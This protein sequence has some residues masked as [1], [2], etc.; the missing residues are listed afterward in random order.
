MDFLNR[1][2]I[3]INTTKVGDI[4]FFVMNWNFSDEFKIPHDWRTDIV[5]TG[6]GSN[7]YT[8]PHTVHA[9]WSI[10]DLNGINEEFAV[11]KH[12]EL[13][14]IGQGFS[15]MENIL[16]PI[17]N[18]SGFQTRNSRHE[19]NSKMVIGDG[20]VAAES[21]PT[22]GLTRDVSVSYGMDGPFTDLVEKF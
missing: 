11:D 19:F 7:A 5:S 16:I 3:R 9:T 22:P 8:S 20:G 4:E 13:T 1:F 14:A 15:G 18:A 2:G 6:A 12:T 17:T 21:I 10:E